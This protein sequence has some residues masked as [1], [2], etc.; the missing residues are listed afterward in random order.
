MAMFSVGIFVVVVS[1]IRLYSL[2]HFANTENI[3]WNY[4]EAGLW[5]LI[6]ID[7]SIVCGCMPA[8]RLLIAKLW[9]K[10]RSTLNTGKDTSTKVSGF[11]GNTGSAG[12]TTDKLN[13]VSIKP[14]ARDESDFVQL[15][16]MD[17]NSDRAILAKEEHSNP[18]FTGWT[19][20]S[21][22]DDFRNTNAVATAITTNERS[23][24]LD[25]SKPARG[26]EHV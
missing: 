12:T 1:V 19:I 4:V 17:N 11:L 22:T 24:D 23:Y 3:T 13:K 20:E 10:I 25:M 21:A 15:V 16:D 2:I 5:S 18:E 14:K 8:H 26:K 7:V 9:P 6:E